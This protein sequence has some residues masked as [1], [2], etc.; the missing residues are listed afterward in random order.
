[1]T[2]ALY[3]HPSS[4]THQMPD[5]HPEQIARIKVI[6]DILSDIDGLTRITA[7]DADT[8]DIL[9]CHPQAYLDLLTKASPAS[10]LVALDADTTMSPGTLS[11]A[12]YAVGANCAA[13][14]LVLSGGAQNAFVATRPPG[15]HAERETPMGFCLFGNIA[16]AA[17]RALD[18][19][20]LTRVAVVDF[21]VHHGNG[22]AD[23]LWS[24]DRVRFVSSHQMP[25]WPGSGTPSEAGAQGQ[26]TNIPF[27]PGTGSQSFRRTYEREVLPALHDY[28]PELVL[29][30]AGFD[31]HADDPLAQMNLTTDDFSW[32]TER[33]CDLADATADGRIVST[34]E[35]G[36][37]LPA[38]AA[39]TAAHVTV[40]KERAL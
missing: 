2:T 30:S 14:D 33:L 13:V 34:L 23:L 38:L 21:D 35:G 18:H 10:G 12:R 24:E 25:L 3:T 16:I 5:G 20:G 32:I 9:R 4:L 11:A 37:D 19:H 26:I 7:P 29:I 27:A 40:L 17:K 15:H 1:M 39:S 22:T 28:A 6:N 8:A 31:A 36:Y